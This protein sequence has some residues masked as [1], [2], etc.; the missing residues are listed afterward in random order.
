MAKLTSQQLSLAEAQTKRL[1]RMYDEAEKDILA[2]YNSALLIASPK[3]LTALKD[4]IKIIRQEILAG[5]RIWCD[6]AVEMLFDL[7]SSE[8]DKSLGKE[9]TATSLR[10]KS[11]LADNAYESLVEVDS[12]IGRRVDQLYRL[13]S[14]EQLKGELSEH[15]TLEQVAQAQREKLAEQGITGF[16]DAAGKQWNIVTYVEMLGQLVTSLTSRIK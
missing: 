5:S 7:A 6:E 10:A 11:F 4:N 13:L 14:M 1:V 16:K 8:V 12:V 9:S 2:E 15:D 3:G